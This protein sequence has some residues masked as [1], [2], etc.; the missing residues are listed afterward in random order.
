MRR[1]ESEARGR[2]L[3]KHLLTQCELKM[4]AFTLGMAA[5]TAR[6]E[7]SMARWDEVQVSVVPR[8]T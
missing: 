5:V 4:M 1:L 2:A 8:I 7:V 3:N 6:G